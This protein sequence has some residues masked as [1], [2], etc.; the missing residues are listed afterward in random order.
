VLGCLTPYGAARFRRRQ[1]AEH[2]HEEFSSGRQCFR[3]GYPGKVGRTLEE[4]RAAVS[5]VFPKWSRHRRR[6]RPFLFLRTTN[7]SRPHKP[8]YK[9]QPSNVLAFFQPGDDVNYIAVSANM[10]SPNIVLHEY[11]HF[12]LRENIGGLPLWIS[13]GLA[14]VTAPLSWESKTSSRSAALLNNTS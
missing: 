14:E 6:R 2:S 5:M 13:E 7:R 4:F 10:A 8:L 3:F 1:V 12:L 11:V 9:G